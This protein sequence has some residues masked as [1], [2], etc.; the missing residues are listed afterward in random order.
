MNIFVFMK[1]HVIE[2]PTLLGLSANSIE[3]DR[4]GMKIL[5]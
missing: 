5:R 4:E 1:D 3:N 2:V